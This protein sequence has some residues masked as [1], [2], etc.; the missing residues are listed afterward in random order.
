MSAPKF[1]SSLFMEHAD[2]CFFIFVDDL[3][4]IRMRLPEA[5]EERLEEVGLLEDPVAEKLEFFAFTEERKGICC[6][7]LQCISPFRL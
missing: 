4:D 5:E 7:W 3:H 6:V 1:C 2:K